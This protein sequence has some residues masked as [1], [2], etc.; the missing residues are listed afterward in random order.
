MRSVHIIYTGGTIGMVADPASGRLSNVALDHLGKDVPEL[1]RLDLKLSASTFQEPIDSCDMTPDRWLQLA[2]RIQE[3]YDQHDG[4]VI[5]HGTDTMAYTASALSFLLQGLQKP[6]ILTGSQLPMGTLRTDGKEN[7][8]TAVEI[9]GSAENGEAIVQEVAVY[10]EYKL[11]RGNRITK[12]SAAHFDAY[13]SPNWPFLAEAGIKIAY[14]KGALL[15]KSSGPLQVANSLESSVALIKLFPGMDSELFKV[16]ANG[17]SKAV[18]LETFGSGNVPSDKKFL[19]ALGALVERGIPVMNVSQCIAGSVLIGRYGASAALEEMGVTGLYDM[20]TESAITK[21]MYLLGK[22]VG[23][24][25][26]GEEM[27]RPIC[28]ELSLS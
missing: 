13:D 10:F 1:D 21:L 16:L 22:G 5:M 2:K 26:I 24:E 23:P 25:I 20:T 12:V 7:L 14:D 8:I 28:G 18:V 15:P 17:Q 27:Q 19:D 9:A 6:V 4:F 3:L 11:Y